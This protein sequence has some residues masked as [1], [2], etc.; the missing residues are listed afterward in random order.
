MIE[1]FLY[2]KR[3]K[4]VLPKRRISFKPK[5]KEMVEIFNKIDGIK[6]KSEVIHEALD[7]WLQLRD[8]PT[9]LMNRLRI[10]YPNKWKYLNRKKPNHV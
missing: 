9:G 8:N 2:R 3:R 10:M 6:G 4:P 5:N 1:S 7:L